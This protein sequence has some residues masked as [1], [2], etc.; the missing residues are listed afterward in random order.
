MLKVGNA[1]IDIFF[2][3]AGCLQ[4]SI[5]EVENAKVRPRKKSLFL[6]C[7]L[8][9]DYSTV[10]LKLSQKGSHY[11]EMIVLF[12]FPFGILVIENVH[13]LFDYILLHVE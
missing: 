6:L 2:F 11:Q 1:V 8:R 4:I 13:F 12:K 5:E 7:I 3:W 10:I 9:K